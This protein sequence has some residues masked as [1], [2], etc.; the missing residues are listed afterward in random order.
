MKLRFEEAK[1]PMRG[2]FNMRVFRNGMLIEE[3]RESNLI[4]TGARTAVARHLMGECEGG[5]IAKIAFGTSGNIP[6]PDDTAITNALIKP[7]LG[8]SLISPTQVEFK[9]ILHK[10]EGNGKKIIE[11]GLLCE[12]ETLFA[13]KVR[14]EAIPKEADFHLE[15]EWI[16]KL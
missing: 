3:Y 4:V 5:H 15:G 1:P 13:R 8:T 7:L 11:F 10:D 2:C 14:S 9:W 12:N 16:I 6:T